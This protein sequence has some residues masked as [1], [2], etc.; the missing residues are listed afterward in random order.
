MSKFLH[1]NE[2]YSILNSSETM[3]F[4]VMFDVILR[5]NIDCLLMS[6]EMDLLS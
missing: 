6:I 5:F 1:V 4:E 2:N 3:Q